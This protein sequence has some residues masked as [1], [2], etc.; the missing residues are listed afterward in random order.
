M[1]TCHLAASGGC[2]GLPDR[3]MARKDAPPPPLMRKSQGRIVPASAYDAEALERYPEGTDFELRSMTRRSLPQLRLYWSALNNAVEATGRWPTP[4]ALHTALKVRLGRVEPIMDL[5]GK[6]IGM[7]PDSTAF[8]KMRQDEFKI[9][10]DQAMAA[11][12]EA[13]GFDPLG[14]P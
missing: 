9:Y 8:D 5:Q 1:T 14:M 4:E 2:D 7:R 3:L 10:F 11:L 12:A 6:V 13:C